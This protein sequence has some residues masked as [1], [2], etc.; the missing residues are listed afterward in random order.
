MNLFKKP[1]FLALSMAFVLSFL[2][3]H[4]YAANSDDRDNEELANKCREL[5]LKIDWLSRYQD[6]PTCEKN[7]DG[8]SVFFAGHYLDKK[9]KLKTEELLEE[10][11]VKLGFSFEVGCYGQNEIKSLIL[12]IKVLLQAI[13]AS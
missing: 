13:D 3:M 12:D 4:A 9:N 8:A 6:R 1:C 5:A 7:L 11:L 10:A 2:S